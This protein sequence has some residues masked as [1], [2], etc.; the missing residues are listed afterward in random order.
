MHKI[1]LKLL[2]R[3]DLISVHV[4]AYADLLSEES[5]LLVRQVRNRLLLL[6]LG[7]ASLVLAVLWGGMALL[8]WSALPA[9]DPRSAWVLWAFPL[10]WAVLAAACGV[11][12][13]MCSTAVFFPRVREQIEMDVLA[14]KQAGKA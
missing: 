5:G 10:A 4:Q 6:A 1:L 8:L 3:P 9:L 11:T 12:Y 2:L 7:I 13:R 14:L